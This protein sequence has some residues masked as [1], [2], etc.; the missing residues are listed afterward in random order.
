MKASASAGYGAAGAQP[1]GGHDGGPPAAV[2]VDASS[3][4]GTITQYVYDFGDGSPL[5]TSTDSTATH[6]YQKG[7]HRGPVV[8]QVTDSLGHSVVVSAG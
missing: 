3:S 4:R 8:V 1:A 6:Q 7:A 2:S 5:V